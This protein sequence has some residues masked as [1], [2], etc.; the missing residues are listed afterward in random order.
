MPAGTTDACSAFPSAVGWAPASDAEAGGLHRDWHAVVDHLSLTPPEYVEPMGFTSPN[1]RPRGLSSED[2]WGVAGAV[3]KELA[4]T[5]LSAFPP[6]ARLE[7][8]V[9]LLD[10]AGNT[11]EELRGALR[12][13]ERL[14]RW[15][16]GVRPVL[17]HL[18]RMTGAHAGA[19]LT[20][21]DIGTGGADIPRAICRWAR[22]RGLPVR[23]EAVDRNDHA[24]AAAAEWS[25]EYPEIHLRQGEASSLPYPDRGF[26]YVIASLFLHHL[27]E[28]QGIRQLQEMHRMARRGLIVSDLWRGRPAH[29]LTTMA[30]RILSRNRLTRHDGPLSILRGFRGHELLRMAAL[31]DLPGPA[32]T[33]HP[34]FRV[35][36]VASR[37]QNE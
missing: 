30:T 12:D 22:R 9:E 10:R 28:A 20:V 35:A 36:L 24:L 7:S 18:D 21:L 32:I 25:A 13:L 1:S 23:I 15:F 26:D 2:V 19:S 4:G 17:F 31:A 11:A 33:R 8:A 6:L 5:L 14:N 29:L 34:W 16:G 37:G 27:S 3:L